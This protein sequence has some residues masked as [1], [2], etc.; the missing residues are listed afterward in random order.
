MVC[1]PYAPGNLQNKQLA[2]P[3]TV[4]GGYIN[5]QDRHRGTDSFKCRKIMRL[6]EK[7]RKW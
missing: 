1:T 2:N 4:S 3:Q 5:D 7:S 6:C